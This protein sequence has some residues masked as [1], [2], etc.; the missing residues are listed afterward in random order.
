MMAKVVGLIGE[1]ESDTDVLGTIIRKA[2]PTRRFKFKTFHGH[3]KGKIIGKCN[4]WA[5]NLRD[6]ECT[7]LVLAQDLDEESYAKVVNELKNALE[8]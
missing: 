1:D 7:A 6:R 8:P 5:K 2:S 3:G 4:Q